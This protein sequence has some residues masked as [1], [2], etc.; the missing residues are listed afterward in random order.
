M[1]GATGPGLQ[2]HRARTRTRGREGL[3]GQNQDKMTSIRIRITGP[4]QGTQHQDEYQAKRTRIS[5]LG[6]EPGSQ[7]QDY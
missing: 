1:T 7:D 5:S 6:P 4:G 2:D 3:Q